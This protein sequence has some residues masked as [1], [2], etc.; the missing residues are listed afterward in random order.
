MNFQPDSS[1]RFNRLF[2]KHGIISYEFDTNIDKT[3]WLFS[4]YFRKSSVVMA[5][6]IPNYLFSQYL[7][8]KFR[9]N[10]NKCNVNSWIIYS[11]ITDD[12]F[13]DLSQIP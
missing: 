8:E 11:R 12:I 9:G 6:D 4:R 13:T 10:K 7:D 5:M 1:V 3:T 2:F